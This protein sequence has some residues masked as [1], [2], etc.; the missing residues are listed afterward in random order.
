MKAAH[1][2]LRP[3]LPSQSSAPTSAGVE[4]RNQR[5][6]GADAGVRLQLRIQEGARAAG[7]GGDENCRA[8][9]DRG[10]EASREGA[11]GKERDAGQ[12]H[13]LDADTFDLDT[14]PKFFEGRC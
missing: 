13:A 2:R 8:R 11:Q 4:R 7:R 6:H 9:L 14:P 12:L 1:S 3:P 10:L 5:T